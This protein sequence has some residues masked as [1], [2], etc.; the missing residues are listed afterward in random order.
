MSS[1]ETKLCV[2][3]LMLLP[4]GCD[5]HY[6]PSSKVNRTTDQEWH[7]YG[8]TWKYSSIA[9][10]REGPM[11]GNQGGV[12]LDA[13]STKISETITDTEGHSFT[14][15]DSIYVVQKNGE[16]KAVQAKFILW[17]SND[18]IFI[19]I[20]QKPNA[21]TDCLVPPNQDMHANADG[22]ANLLGEWQPILHKFHIDRYL[23]EYG[24]ATIPSAQRISSA[25]HLVPH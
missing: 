5:I 20:R 15:Q 24:N 1:V 2:L 19:L 8:Q 10:G 3:F 18:R 22:T 17:S 13:S 9:S 11:L 23:T 25:G 21:V 12:L 16:F 6:A 4:I 14:I 7:A